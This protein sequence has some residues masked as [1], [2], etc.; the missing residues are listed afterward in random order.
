MVGAG[1]FDLFVTAFNK[2][3]LY[4][5]NVEKH[6]ILPGWI[7]SIDTVQPNTNTVI[8]THHS[9]WIQSSI[10][11]LVFRLMAVSVS[12]FLLVACGARTFRRVCGARRNYKLARR[13][14]TDRCR[15][16]WPTNIYIYIY[17]YTGGPHTPPPK[18]I[19]EKGR[20]KKAVQRECWRG[21]WIVVPRN[22]SLLGYRINFTRILGFRTSYRVELHRMDRYIYCLDLI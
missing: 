16:R 3:R 7:V 10:A 9:V 4:V 2:K 14:R 15:C 12:A 21:F 20:G 13:F 11:S 19:T 5:E 22:R 17:I 6:I 18:E 1:S 8:I